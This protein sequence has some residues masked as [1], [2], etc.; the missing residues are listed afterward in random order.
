MCLGP[1]VSRSDISIR[2][3][4]SPSATQCLQYS[5]PLELNHGI[6]NNVE[7]LHPP[8]G[9]LAVHFPNRSIET[10]GV[11][12][13]AFNTSCSH[14]VHLPLHILFKAPDPDPMVVWD[15][16]CTWRRS[17]VFLARG[18][19]TCSLA[20]LY[21]FIGF[22]L[23]S[24]HR[25]ARTAPPLHLQASLREESTGPSPSSIAENGSSTISEI[26]TI[27][28]DAPLNAHCHPHFTNGQPLVLNPRAQESARPLIIPKIVVQDFS[29][30]DGSV[31]YKAPEYDLTHALKRRRRLSRARVPTAP[32]DHLLVNARPS[33][34]LPPIPAAGGL[35][36]LYLVDGFEYRR[37]DV[38]VQNVVKF[39][40]RKR[41]LG[42]VVAKD[43][44]FVIVGL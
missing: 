38:S 1:L 17:L 4:L 37:P 41:G 12:K 42:D 5:C 34:R 25:T 43:G 2:L 27:G 21:L 31:R 22:V 29:A 36:P 8:P 24:G 23:C 9:L 39:P 10:I 6:D 40:G 19:F 30:E 44:S 33:V 3:D 13:A 35:R 7:I 15:L 16:V 20:V 28:F 18:L 11:L 14:H 32:G 26:T